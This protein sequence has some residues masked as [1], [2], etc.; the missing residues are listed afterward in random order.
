M[1]G[2]CGVARNVDRETDDLMGDLFGRRPA[3]VGKKSKSK[4]K[5]DVPAAVKAAIRSAGYRG[6]ISP[7]SRIGTMLDSMRSVEMIM[8]LEEQFG[9]SIPESRLVSL[10]TV[11]DVVKEVE[12]RI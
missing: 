10:N 7:S 11:G 5:S 8:S 3:K 12:K 1:V 4:L 2:G 6:Q 9:I